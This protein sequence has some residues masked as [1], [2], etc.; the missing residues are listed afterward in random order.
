[1][2]IYKKKYSFSFLKVYIWLT[3]SQQMHIYLPFKKMHIPMWISSSRVNV[4]V[5]GDGVVRPISPHFGRSIIFNLECF[6]L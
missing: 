1:M 6:S 3:H 4:H 5:V 2:Y